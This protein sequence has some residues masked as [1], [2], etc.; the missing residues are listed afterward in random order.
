MAKGYLMVRAVL[1][2]ANDRPA[3]EHWYVT[4][5]MPQAIE[6]FG[7]LRGWRYWNRTDPDVHFA[8]YEFA[9]VAEAD[10]LVSSSALAG[11][12]AE[13]NRVWGSRVSRTREILEQA[14]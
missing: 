6:A 13:F 10:A 9:S 1:A 8:F 11:M 12:V 2:D 3:F 14:P 4:E 5:H 7:A